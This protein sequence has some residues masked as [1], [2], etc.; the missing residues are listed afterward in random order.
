MQGVP[1]CWLQ[2][3]QQQQ[4]QVRQSIGASQDRKEQCAEFYS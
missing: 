4:Q 2:Q 1:A 3:Q